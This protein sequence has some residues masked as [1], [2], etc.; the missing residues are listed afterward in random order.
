MRIEIDA[1]GA[2]IVV[3]FEC[4]RGMVQ[5]LELDTYPE[6]LLRLF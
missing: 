6:L 4:D 2:G 1:E 3:E 5:R